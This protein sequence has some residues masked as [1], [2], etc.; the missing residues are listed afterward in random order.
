MIV[1]ALAST[2]APTL[3]PASAL[4]QTVGAVAAAGATPLVGAHAHAIA[5]TLARAAEAHAAGAL[6]SP[7]LRTSPSALACPLVAWPRP[8]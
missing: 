8:H 3:E 5:D 1:L 4:A 6:P 7:L 2:G